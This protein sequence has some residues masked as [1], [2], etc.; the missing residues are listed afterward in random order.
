MHKVGDHW[1]KFTAHEKYMMVQT[2]LINSSKKVC[3][4][5]LPFVLI[6]D[7]LT[8][9]L[10]VPKYRCSPEWFVLQGK[11]KSLIKNG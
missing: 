8:V 11:L 7:I 6:D 4:A 10:K 9:R 5:T 1:D 3:E 2:L